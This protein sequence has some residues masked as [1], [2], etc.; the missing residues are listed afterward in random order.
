LKDVI[1]VAR[2]KTARLS[3]A[4]VYPDKQGHNVMKQVGMVS[5]IRKLDDENKTLGSLR[6]Q[7]GD[8][9]DIAIYC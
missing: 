8:F 3:F 6:F 2:R 1:P 9:L 7:T 5:G 4:F